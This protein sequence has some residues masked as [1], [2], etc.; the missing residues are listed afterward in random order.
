MLR[1]HNKFQAIN[2]PIN[3]MA[4]YIPL[5]EWIPNYSRDNFIS[6]INAAIVVTILLIPQS[7]AYAMLAGIPAEVG[8]YASIL[9]LVLYAIF[10]TSKTLSV[11]PVAVV[12]LMTATTL[13]DIAAQG[14][15]DYLTAAIVLSL[16]SGLMLCIMGLLRLGFITAYLSHTVISGFI[17]ASGII[18]AL[19]QLKH[20]LGIGASGD[21]AIDI[22]HSL[23]TN[24]PN[25][26][27]YTLA[28]GIGVIL[29]SYG[30]K[31]YL[32]HFFSA[33]GINEKA[34]FF[35]GK[36]A[37]ILSVL[38]SILII[39][40]F[41]LHNKGVAIVGEIPSGLPTIGFIMP[42]IELVNTL[43]LPALMIAIIGYIESISI[44]KTLAAKRRQR[45]DPDQELIGLGMANIG[46]S[47]SG[48][49]PVTGGVSRSIVNYDA[50][51]QTQVAS[52][53]SAIGVAIASLFLTPFLYYLPKATLAAT[54]IIAVLSL[55]DF[56]I[57]KK[58]WRYSKSDFY[59][60]LI[61]VV[62]TLLSGVEIGVACGVIT[63]ISLHLYRT[64]KPHVAEV[65]LIKGT[66]HFRNIHRYTVITVPEILT[67]RPDQSIY[68]ANATYL[69]DLVYNAIYQNKKIAHV[70]FQ[71]NAINEI[72][73]SALE[74]LEEVTQRLNDQGIL[75]HFSEVK[76]PVM[77]SLH[78]SDFIT[79]LT[80]EIYLTQYQAFTEICNQYN[81]QYAK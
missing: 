15:Q 44:G 73:F 24:I 55:I 81:Y 64:S 67:L 62:V 36:S 6:D 72:D 34:A 77:D 19:S 32:F 8:L 57:F 68:F 33:I 65:G 21:N 71:C 78:H 59:A 5:L 54:I 49:F 52:I 27:I 7:L 50:G 1:S 58:T 11:G 70:I 22:L 30:I 56:S 25:T 53:F 14:S 10:G 31:N 13:G 23:L 9:P 18:I 79:H 76:G 39:Y 61:T 75:L 37:P 43:L 17:T 63:S 28:L 4:K 45:I 20:V 47:V 26:N 60:V 74:V 3:K 51:A 80:G 12:S 16:L 69:Q 41:M 66:E 42:S 2:L 38:A 35:F 48:A 46:S 29:F 40:S